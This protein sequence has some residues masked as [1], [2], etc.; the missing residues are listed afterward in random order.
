MM[1]NF[2]FSTK[3]PFSSNSTKTRSMRTTTTLSLTHALYVHRED[4]YLARFIVEGFRGLPISKL[5]QRRQAD[6]P[7]EQEVSMD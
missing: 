3:K 2:S 6:H 7:P 4:D 5:K 1:I